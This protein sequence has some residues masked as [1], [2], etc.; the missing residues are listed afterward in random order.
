MDA[1][2]HGSMEDAEHRSMTV[3]VPQFQFLVGG[4]F[5]FLGVWVYIDESLRYLWWSSGCLRRSWKNS[6]HLR[7]AVS[8]YA[9]LDSELYFYLL[10]V[11]GWHSAPVFTRQF[12]VAFVRILVLSTW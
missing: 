10:L 1:V 3:E 12:T 9:H 2:G 4:G 7:R 5:Q 8:R 11:S 6:T